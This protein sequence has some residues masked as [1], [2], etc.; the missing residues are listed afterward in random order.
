M[1]AQRCCQIIMLIRE[2]E[3]VVASQYLSS[4]VPA[5]VKIAF[6]EQ[7][8]IELLKQY[9][10]HWFPDI[11][12]RGSAYRAICVFTAKKATPYLCKVASNLNISMECFPIDLCLWIDPHHVSY[13][14]AS[15]YVVTIYENNHVLKAIPV[16]IKRPIVLSPPRQQPQPQK[17]G[18][19]SF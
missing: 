10:A 4:Y 6:E 3:F 14:L 5:E 7:L 15:K 17:I 19:E 2:R 9:S 12:S 8:Q 13:R 16:T 1:G 18:V 11:P